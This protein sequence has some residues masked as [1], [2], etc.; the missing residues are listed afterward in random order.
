MM[1]MNKKISRR[2]EELRS[3]ESKLQESS[4]REDD[5][6]SRIEELETGVE[7]DHLM[8]TW[9]YASKGGQRRNHYM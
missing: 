1:E 6:R 4:L 9:K 5:Y 7:F 2:E 8:G 3:Y